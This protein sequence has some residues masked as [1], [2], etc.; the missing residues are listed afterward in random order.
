[1]GRPRISGAQTDDKEENFEEQ[2]DKSDAVAAAQTDVQ[3]TRS[4]RLT[5]YLLI[6]NFLLRLCFPPF[7]QA[8]AAVAS[9]FGRRSPEFGT[10]SGIRY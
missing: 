2:T 9:Q 4:A 10:V 6:S 3:G 8:K 5:F 7:Q 1:M